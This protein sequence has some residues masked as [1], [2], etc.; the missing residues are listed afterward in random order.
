MKGTIFAA[1]F[2]LTG[3]G[4]YSR[5][6]VE[7]THGEASVAADPEDTIIATNRFKTY[8]IAEPKKTE[9]TVERVVDVRFSGGKAMVECEPGSVDFVFLD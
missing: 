5:E 9:F 7:C 2:V 1:V 6:T 8:S 4:G 3:C